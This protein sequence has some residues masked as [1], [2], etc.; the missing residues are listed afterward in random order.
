MLIG[1]I[2]KANARRFKGK[3]ALKDER[4]TLTFEEVDQ[5]SNA[6]NHALMNMGVR[7]GDKI[8]VLLYNNNEYSELLLGLPKAGFVIVPLNYR[9]IGRELKY[10][11]ANSEANT[12]IFGD[13][14]VETIEEIRPELDLVKNYIVVDH[15]GKAGI[16][17]VNYETMIQN[18]PTGEISGDVSESDLAFIMYTSGTTGVPKGVM[19]THKNIL[20][21]LYNLVFEL[22]PK[23]DDI[24]FNNP[25]LYHCAGQ[26]HLMAHFFYGCLTITIKQFHPEL[27]LKIVQAERPNILHLVP[28]MQNMVV[29]HPDVASYDL[30]SV[31]LM[32]YGASSIMRAHL[33]K[34]MEVF[35]CRFLQCAGQTEASPMLSML[36]PEDHVADGPEHLVRRLSS[37]GRE[38]KLTEVRIV[39]SAGNDVPPNV[40]GEEI[41]R[42]DN[43]MAGYWKKPEATASALVDGW[44][45]TGD[46]CMKDEYGYIYYVDRIK[47]MICRGGENVY[48]REVEE[49]ISAHAHVREVAVIGIPDQRLEEEIMALIVPRKGAAISKEDVIE[50]C[51]K[52]LARYKKPRKIKFVD[53]LPKNAT[54]KLLKQELRNQYG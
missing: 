24:I 36:R 32:I 8:A 40:P 29:H 2:V 45:H 16:Q 26:N 35:N 7:K 9:L 13:D 39:D 1:D 3:A 42:G 50:I 4:S 19:L 22:Q 27:V 5:R 33:L 38:P 53:S 51:E 41:A 20:T 21:N 46:I 30:S 43:V 31:E 52:N 34:V 11:I 54:G 10:M 6:V 23:P 15:S 18:A 17:A 49:V 14:F 25:P 44:L 48:P 12:I 47:D 28:A 37:A